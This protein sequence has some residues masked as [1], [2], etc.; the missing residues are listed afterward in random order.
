M[1]IIDPK[2]LKKVKIQSKQGLS[3]LKRY[4]KYFQNGGS[5]TTRQ[6]LPRE[7]GSDEPINED[8]PKDETIKEETV[9]L[10][11]EIKEKIETSQINIKAEEEVVEGTPAYYPP[12][13]SNLT[14]SNLTKD[15]S[16]QTDIWALGI[17]FL[18][19]FLNF[20]FYIILHQINKKQKE[21]PNH[22]HNETQIKQI[23]D[24]AK[25]RKNLS[26]VMPPPIIGVTPIPPQF[27]KEENVKISMEYID[28]IEEE[29]KK[30][31]SEENRTKLE[32]IF[33]LIKNM[34]KFKKEERINIGGK[35]NELTNITGINTGDITI[36]FDEESYNTIL[37][38]SKE[39]SNDKLED[40]NEKLEDENEKRG[41]E[42]RLEDELIGDKYPMRVYKIGNE[43]ENDDFFEINENDKREGCN[44]RN[45][46][47]IVKGEKHHNLNELFIH[48]YL[49]KKDETH[50][51]IVDLYTYKIEKTFFFMYIE[52]VPQALNDYLRDLNINMRELR[53]YYEKS[54]HKTHKPG[55]IVPSVD[56]PNL[57]KSYNEADGVELGGEACHI[58]NKPC[59]LQGDKLGQ[60]IT[61]KLY[62]T[63]HKCKTSNEEL[64]KMVKQG[65]D[66]KIFEEKCIIILKAAEALQ[67]IH[68]KGI[69]HG[70][71]KPDNIVI[72]K[73]IVDNTNKYLVKFI[74]VGSSRIFMNSK[75]YKLKVQEEKEEEKEEEK[76][77]WNDPLLTKMGL[78][79]PSS[80]E[81][82]PEEEAKKRAEKVE[83]MF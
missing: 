77:D 55:R 46:C 8:L 5:S 31:L 49:S 2:T 47:S 23:I 7:T 9:E 37:N 12:E 76:V 21:N 28:A 38:K 67:F 24:F 75:M 83:D 13:V 34:I 59:K 27:I 26:N 40:K 58:Q 19:L 65:I 80:S 72:Q 18:K 78:D 52:H 68:D 81:K 62:G 66:N 17:T 45:S 33:E 51:Y 44:N 3:L 10:P 54:T 39:H 6:N 63:K 25:K 1:F 42:R 79:L 11:P 70:D 53:K 48:D 50:K 56:I 71:I 41:D 22:D 57:Y 43:P 29:Q 82:D 35:V 60:G 64:A 16:L 36:P 73:E 15:Y 20:D 32:G 14:V 74:D 4:V 61:C 30:Y 69:L